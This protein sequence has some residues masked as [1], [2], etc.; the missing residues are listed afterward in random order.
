MINNTLVAPIILLAD[1]SMHTCQNK[2]S[3]I[4]LIDI[5]ANKILIDIT[6]QT[7]QVP[8]VGFHLSGKSIL[9]EAQVRCRHGLIHLVIVFRA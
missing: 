9:E 4:M 6:I 7:T 1:F 8:L 3:L 2:A 5:L